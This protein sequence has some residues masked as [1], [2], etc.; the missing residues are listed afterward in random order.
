MSIRIDYLELMSRINREEFEEYFRVHN[1]KAV[2][3]KFNLHSES[4]ACTLAK[5]WEIKK[6]PEDIKQTLFNT[7]MERYGNKWAQ[8]SEEVRNKISKTVSSSE[9]QQRM[10]NTCKQNHV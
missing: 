8:C 5:K 9:C 7:N 2:A 6:T 4:V 1:A 3:K 10:K